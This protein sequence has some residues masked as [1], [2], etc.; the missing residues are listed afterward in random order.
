MTSPYSFYQ[1]W[2]NMA[3]ADVVPFLGYFT[4]LPMEQIAEVG[5]TVRDRPGGT[6]RPAITG[7]G[8]DAAGPWR[9][10]ACNRPSV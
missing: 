2:L 7:A 4:F 10:T 6:R 9:R 5:V 8:G 3:D 1:Y